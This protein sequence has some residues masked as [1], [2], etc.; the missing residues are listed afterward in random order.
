MDSG[1]EFMF[2][3]KQN[4]QIKSNQIKYILIMYDKRIQNT[5]IIEST[6]AGRG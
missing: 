1:M 4:R 2:K 5:E 3:I 6:D